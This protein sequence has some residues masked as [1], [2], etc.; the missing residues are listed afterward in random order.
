MKV[1]K[2]WLHLEPGKKKAAGTSNKIFKSI[3]NSGNRNL[4]KKID[5]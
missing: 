1:K 5:G 2:L 4:E 3:W